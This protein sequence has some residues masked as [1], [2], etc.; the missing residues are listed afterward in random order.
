MMIKYETT[1]E[2]ERD[3]R[4]LQ[5]KYPSLPDD[6]RIVKQYDIELFHQQ[7]MDK[8]GILKIEN[9]GNTEK[10][11][12]YKIKKFACKYLKGRGS[13][14]GIRVIYAY[15]PLQ[16]KIVFLEIYFKGKQENENRKRIK[17]F[18]ISLKT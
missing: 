8:Q 4:K 9:A 13:R 5:K 2:F 14:S 3:F 16:Q 1:K 18:I 6:L 10:L 7:Q 11:T 12:F 17:N 15:F